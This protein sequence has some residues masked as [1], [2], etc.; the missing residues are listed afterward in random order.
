MKR[1]L[2]TFVLF[3]MTMTISNAQEESVEAENKVS[4]KVSLN[5]GSVAGNEFMTDNYSVTI[6]LD[7]TH[8]YSV[9]KDVS[10]GFSAGYTHAFA[11]DSDESDAK[12]IHLGGAFRL[13]TDNDKFFLGG[14]AGYSL[15]IDDGGFYYNPKIGFVISEHSGVVASYMSIEDIN[16]SAFGIGYEFSF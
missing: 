2:L 5:I 7:F 8:M 13:Y 11:K 12:L 15:G 3:V 16:F 1:V 10:L 6:D 4:D 9:T 14:E